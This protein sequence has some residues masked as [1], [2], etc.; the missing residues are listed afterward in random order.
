MKITEI[1]TT[2][3]GILIISGVV[4]LLIAIIL[5]IIGNKKAKKE[6]NKH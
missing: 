3:P 6:L 5:F 4:L 1:F 2:L